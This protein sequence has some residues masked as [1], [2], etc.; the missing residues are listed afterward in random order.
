MQCQSKYYPTKPC[1]FRVPHS[2]AVVH[3]LQLIICFFQAPCG[4]SFLMEQTEWTSPH[5][6]EKEVSIVLQEHC[7]TVW[8]G[9]SVGICQLWI[10]IFSLSEWNGHSLTNKWINTNNKYKG[11]LNLTWGIEGLC[12]FSQY[13][14]ICDVVWRFI[15]MR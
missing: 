5:S 9:I 1:V 2:A 8:R 15:S 13:C 10:L 4:N 12:Q 14:H 6:W 3:G 7:T 11:L